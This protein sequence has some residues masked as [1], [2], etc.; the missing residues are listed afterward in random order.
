ML[1][2]ALHEV[3]EGEALQ[4][5]AGSA[6]ELG[7]AMQACGGAIMRTTAAP[8]AG[9]LLPLA[10]PA[11]LP[12]S[13]SQLGCGLSIDCMVRHGSM[14]PPATA[15]TRRRCRLC[16]RPSPSCRIPCRRHAFAGVA[17]AQPIPA[18]TP[19]HAASPLR[20]AAQLPAAAAEVAE[21]EEASRGCIDWFAQW[22]PV[23]FVRD[24]PDKEPYSF[25]LLD[26]PM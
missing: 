10:Y 4:G 22:W 20:P 1:H 16:C 23:A 14:L 5:F 6:S 2:G 13:A 9:A 7:T 8:V 24:I 18:R 3:V 17:V 21:A 25:R 19:R 11:A 26:Q 15:L 12:R